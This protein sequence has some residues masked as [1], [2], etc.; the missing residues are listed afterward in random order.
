M[1]TNIPLRGTFKVSCEYHRENTEDLNWAAGFHPGIDLVSDDDTVWSIC[2]GVVVNID[3]NADYGNF[4]VI[5]NDV[6]TKY[7]WY[8]HLRK[9]YVSEG[10]RVDRY[11]NIGLIGATGNVTGKHL[12]LEIRNKNNKYG[13]V[14][15]P[16]E[17]MGIPNK[18]GTYNDKNYPIYRSHLQDI[19]NQDFVSPYHISGTTGQARR[20]EAIQL[21]SDEVEYRVH[22]QDIGWMNWVKGG[23]FIGTTGEARRLEAI[24]FKS[25]REMIVEGHV[26]DIGWQGERRGV[27]VGI[28]TTGKALRLEAFRFKFA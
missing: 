17:Y 8:C 15:N 6:D 3:Y 26:Q 23:T 11:S 1:I 19:G 16:A 18:V 2:N 9:I 21:M 22:L 27:Y 25:N 14:S 13:N 7:Y 4:I 28:G 5:C 12:H 20:M 24:E 10:Q